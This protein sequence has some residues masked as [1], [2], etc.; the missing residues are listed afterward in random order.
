MHIVS[1]IKH[2]LFSELCAES[3][4]RNN[5]KIGILAGTGITDLTNRTGVNGLSLPNSKNLLEK[6]LLVY[7]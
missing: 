2:G 6:C 7:K 4:I 1:D 3:F 5:E